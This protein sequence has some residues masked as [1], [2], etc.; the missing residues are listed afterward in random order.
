M[1]LWPQLRE[2]LQQWIFPRGWSVHA[3]LLFPATAGSGAMVGNLAKSL[4][5]ILE[6]RNAGSGGQNES[7]STHL[8]LDPA[9]DRD[10]RVEAG[11]QGHH[12]DAWTYEPVSHDAVAREMGHA[13]RAGQ[14]D[15]RAPGSGPLN[16]SLERLTAL[17]A[18]GVK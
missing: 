16:G 4:D 5:E 17:T 15:L 7:V 3:G 2:I 12:V 1:P 13:G 9:P 14:E 8:L 6:L 11:T 18:A 10:H